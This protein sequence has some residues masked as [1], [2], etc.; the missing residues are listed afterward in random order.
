MIL[1]P[2]T[3]TVSDSIKPIST[4]VL[5]E[6]AA[7]WMEP[8]SEIAASEPLLRHPRGRERN[9]PQTWLVPGKHTRPVHLAA[10]AQVERTCSWLD[11]Q[12]LCG[13]GGGMRPPESMSPNNK[14][15]RFLSDALPRESWERTGER[16][17]SA[18]ASRLEGKDHGIPSEREE[19]LYEAIHHCVNGAAAQNSHPRSRWMRVGGAVNHGGLA[20]LLTLWSFTLACEK[21]AGKVISRLYLNTRLSDTTLPGRWTY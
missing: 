12:L 3:L 19:Q 9:N 4:P 21:A 10:Y 6:Y 18:S 17:A 8:L 2:K 1:F 16:E 14:S 5:T 15:I 11:T 13:C 20:L 7:V